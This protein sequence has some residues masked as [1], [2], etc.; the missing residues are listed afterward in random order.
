MEMMLL[1][2][3]KNYLTNTVTFI[4]SVSV[5]LFVLFF[6]I[7]AYSQAILNGTD[8][9]PKQ[10][11]T[12]LYTKVLI[13][14]FEDKMYLSDA[15]KDI[16]QASAVKDHKSIKGRFRDG[17]MISLTAGSKLRYA[18]AAFNFRDSL[19]HDDLIEA[20][21]AIK[22]KYEPVPKEEKKASSIFKT[23][24]EKPETKVEKGEVVSQPDP[25]LKYMKTVIKKTEVLHYL[26]EKY[27]ADL[28]LFISQFEIKN[29][30][31]DPNAFAYGNFK[32]NVRVHYT[33]YN[34]NSELISG[35]I[36]EITVPSDVKEISHIISGNFSDLAGIIF[37]TV[38]TKEKENE[39]AQVKKN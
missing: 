13:I 33:F 14:P 12:P 20:F 19:I 37:N 18:C 29:D 2:G 15:D 36:A 7:S 38:F 22:Y 17:L 16:A 23:V 35:G 11:F 21:S 5:L 32:R 1:E 24:A 34:Q 8:A 9:Q 31:S 39:E 6:Q 26:A 3:L 30:L 27:E 10:E 28:F 25:N 4:R